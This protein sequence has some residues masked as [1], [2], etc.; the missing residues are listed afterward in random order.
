MILSDAQQS[1]IKHTNGPCLVLAVPGAGK[2]T[3]ILHR[4]RYL[5]EEVGVPANKILSITFSKAQA[6]DMENR[7][8]KEFTP[9]PVKFSTIHSLAYSVLRDHARKQGINYILIEST[10]NKISKYSIVR[11]I[12][13]NIS[14]EYMTDDLS[15]NIFNA[16]GY[17]KNSMTDPETYKDTNDIVDYFPKVFREYEAI[18]RKNN[19]I[20]FDDMLTL[21]YEIL[22]SD[23]AILYSYRNKYEYIQLDEGQDTSFV[24]VKII[25]LL[26]KPKNNLFVV[27][28]DDQ[29]IYSF[30]GADSQWLLNF[31]E[32]YKDAKFYFIEENYRSQKYI[33]DALNKFI[34]NNKN[35]Y[36]KIVRTRKNKT[37]PIEIVKP[38]DLIDQYKFIEEKIKK[39]NEDI[40]ILYRN[41]LSAIGLIDYF[42][43]RNIKFKLKD[44]KLNFFRHRVLYDLIAFFK[45]AYDDKNIDAFERIY[46][47]M[48]GYISKKQVLFA[49]N[50]SATMP[51]FD[52]IL[53][54][55]D[56]PPFYIENIM[57]LKYD[58]K[59]LAT[60]KPYDALDW[61][62]Y[63]LDYRRYIKEN[64]GIYGMS[65]HTMELVFFYLK[66]IAKDTKDTNEL[67]QRIKLLE[68][69]S[70]LSHKN[71]GAIIL[72]TIH[73]AKGLEFKNVILIDLFEGILPNQLSKEQVIKNNPLLFEEERRLFYVGMSRAKESL[74]LIAPRTLDNE[75][76]DQSSF[77]DELI[78]K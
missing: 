18:K 62:E 31:K 50:Y 33:V 32:T 25:E 1:A 23:K 69:L 17:V 46:F 6:L 72:S 15:E 65:V 30:R 29:S 51:I 77:I 48:K 64:S 41:N 16:I 57:E 34:I 74:T 11:D 8:K 67:F 39:D 35:R 54:F 45:F 13:K 58:F 22:C 14:G 47:K 36:K 42:E 27:A 75:N 44:T 70:L 73:R 19:Y 21:T 56:L 12:I 3:V 24:Q 9:Y 40:A 2:T 59:K 71:E 53:N 60:L 4:L 52:R 76:C 38:K 49:K 7:F 37:L 55:P 63:A 28:D 68:K 61:I 20:D 5:I 78:K 43:K 66:L 26:S 10:N